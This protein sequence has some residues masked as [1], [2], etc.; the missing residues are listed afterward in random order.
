[1]LSQDCPQRRQRR[2]SGKQCP[3]CSWVLEKEVIG[4]ARAREGAPKGQPHEPSREESRQGHGLLLRQGVRQLPKA[5]GSSWVQ[6]NVT[7]SH[8]V[9]GQKETL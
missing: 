2:G 5:A 1:M 7:K 8:F 6:L 9:M 4:G 3:V